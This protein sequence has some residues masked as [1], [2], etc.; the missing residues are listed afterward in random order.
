MD[1]HSTVVEWTIQNAH[2]AGILLVSSAG[3]DGV[4]SDTHFPASL[5][6][7]VGVAAVDAADLKAS[8]S[9]YGSIVAISAPGV[10]IVSTYLFHGYAVWSGTSMAA[11]F[12]SGAGA[13]A[14]DAFPGSTPDEV[15]SRIENAAAPMDHSGQPYE[16]LMGAGRLDVFGAVVPQ[17]EF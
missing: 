2:T 15:R 3:N 8:F 4:E 12:I 14:F 7:V 10:G 6:E 17:T 13:L 1:A 16:G 11:P 5:P 9:N